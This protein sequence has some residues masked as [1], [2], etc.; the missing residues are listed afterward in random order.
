MPCTTVSVQENFNQNIPQ[1]NL[2]SR[3]ISLSTVDVI[4]IG[5]AEP[6]KINLFISMESFK[7]YVLKHPVR[8]YYIFVK[9][10]YIHNNV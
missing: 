1:Q 10:Y 5:Y 4:S 7:Q 3:N 2:H 6:D 9:R 8:L